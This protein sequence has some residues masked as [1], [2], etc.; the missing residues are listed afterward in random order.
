MKTSSAKAKGRKA[1]KEAKALILSYVPELK[2]ADI[3]VTSSGATGRDLKFSP[4]ASK[5]LPLAIECK[6]QERLNIW[7]ALTQ[8]EDNSTPDE[9]PVVVFR[10]NG[11]QL[12]VALGFEQFLALLKRTL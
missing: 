5:L 11:A 12:H 7:D 4:L 2:D 1:C 6:N 8:A 10:R 3:Q 9:V